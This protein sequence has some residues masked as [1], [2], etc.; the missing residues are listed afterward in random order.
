MERLTE[1]RTSI[2]VAHRLSTA[3]AA[4]HVLV[5]D[6][7]ELVEQGAHDQLLAARGVYAALHADWSAGT[8]ARDGG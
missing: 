1:G 8:E 5:F 3:E 2:T 6:R 7:G 4:D